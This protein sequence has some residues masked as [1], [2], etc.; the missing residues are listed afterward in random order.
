[1]GTREYYTL[2]AS[3]PALPYFERASRL[4]INEVRLRKRMEMLDGDHQI[5]VK[6][7]IQLIAWERQPMERTDRDVTRLYGEIEG[8]THNY[9]LIWTMIEQ[10]MS[11][12]TVL[13]ALRRRMKGTGPPGK[14]ERWGVGPWL[15]H[16]I[17]HWNHPDFMLGLVFPWITKA[18]PLLDGGQALELQRLL[19]KENW[20][21]ATQVSEKNPFAFEA[22]IAYL[23]RWG[24]ISTWLGNDAVAA[25]SRFNTLVLEVTRGQEKL[26]DN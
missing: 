16:I 4:P 8:L 10:G 3:L 23:S 17:H 7:I 11:Q 24:A 2:M 26:F 19:L 14:H 15:D 1:M 21:N 6:K 18:R 12:R 25:G 9:P 13:A 20:K 22:V 5:M